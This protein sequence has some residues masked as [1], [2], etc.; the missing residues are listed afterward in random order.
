MIGFLNPSWL[1][2][3]PAAGLPLILHL[4]ARRQPPTVP[5]PAVRYL[6]QVTRDHQRRLKL[7]HWLLLL[8]RTLLVLALV[9][10]AAGPT[11]A[12]DG[13]AGHAPASL[14]LILDNSPSS[15]AVTGG[16]PALDR[17]RA[18]AREVLDKA[19]TEDAIWLLT[20]DG[21]ARRAP[22]ERLRETVDSLV[23]SETRLDLGA[24]LAEA[25]DIL[26]NQSPPAEIVLLSDLQ[27]SALSP[28]EVELPLVVGMPDLVSPPNLGVAALDPGPQP[29]SPGIN[30]VRVRLLGDSGRSSPMAL[31]IGNR[32]SRPQLGSVGTVVEARLEAPT[33]GWWPVTAEIDADEFR[34]DDR[35][36]TLVRVVPVARAQ[37]DPADHY[38]DAAAVTLRAGGRLVDGSEV[39][40]GWLGPGASVVPPP[41][42]L[43]A[44]GSL[45][46]A[47]E[48]RGVPWRFG[49]PVVQAQRTDSGS[50]LAPTAVTRRFRL[51]HMG[52]A[53]RGIEATVSGDPWIVRSGDVVLIG[54]RFDPSWSALP[55]SAGFVP[56]V[57]ALANRLVRGEQALLSGVP[58]TPILLPDAVDQ[59][60]GD[61]RSWPVEG[62]A[63]WRPPASGVYY[64]RSGADTVGALAVNLD[65]R[66]SELAPATRSEVRALW[67]AARLIPLADVRAAAFAAGARGHL[68]GPLL[69]LALLLGLVE[70][71]LASLRRKSA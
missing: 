61:S 14:V 22:I 49:G 17:L 9:L 31:L 59:V 52:G 67:P 32:S 42:D 39:T 48:R 24:A 16:T 2:A 45:N 50:L 56:L 57:D 47:L 70:V 26:V 54:S 34:A 62:G 38:L 55:T 35:R 29:W 71:A 19:T 43:A 23:P 44:V 25:R 65:P 4:V 21:V 64:L 46:R 63:A 60:L 40:L 15:G 1:W 6:Q 20:A 68:R 8:V 66:E 69:V 27:A 36:S 18:A 28:A 30:R 53:P 12:R 11:V 58:G 10:A 13:L 51:V 3:L 41:A 37:W 7:Q 33:P 5:F